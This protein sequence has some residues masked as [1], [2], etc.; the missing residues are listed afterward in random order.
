[1]IMCSATH[2]AYNL[3]NDLKLIEL[4]RSEGWLVLNNKR[5]MWMVYSMI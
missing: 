2:K 1:M 4:W 3:N 5:G